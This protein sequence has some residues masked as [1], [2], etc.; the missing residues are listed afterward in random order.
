M[1]LDEAKLEAYCLQNIPGFKGP[2][3]WAAP[4]GPARHGLTLGQFG[5]G[6]S[7]P[8]YVMVDGNGKRY[9]MRKKPPGKIVSPTA[10]QVDREYRI[11]NALANSGIDFP[12]PKP[13]VLCQDPAI[14]GTDFYVM[15]FRGPGRINDASAALPAA[16]DAAER[17]A[18]WV[19]MLQTLAKLHK[20]DYKKIGLQGFG[21]DSGY[22]Q[23][24]IQNWA[25][26]SRQQARVKN[27]DDGREVGD[28]VGLDEQVAWFERNMVTDEA[29][30]F[31]GDFFPHNI[32]FD[33]NEPK[34]IAVLD[35][36]LAT[37]G[38]PLSDLAYLLIPYYRPG[39]K[40]AP[41]IPTLEES[42]KIYCEAVGRPWPIPGFEFCI[43]FSNF[44][45]AI[46]AQGI[47]ARYFQKQNASPRA[48]EVAET[49]HLSNQA[50]L[51]L[52]ARFGELRATKL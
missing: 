45:S 35:W 27:L 11:L 1:K 38:H 30:I 34:I 6:Q 23:R 37:I 40:A 8:T 41:G 43:A 14:V 22:Y 13:Y 36:E 17:R 7:N 48:K 47:A 18:M 51:D 21:K 26:L 9:V 33:P 15:E 4:R 2:M 49:W 32:M 44:R 42:Q 10:H 24:N 29:T 31:H 3:M 28:A 16:K 20:V 39:F 46:I 19:E 50:T 52:I 5:L 12:S 25:R